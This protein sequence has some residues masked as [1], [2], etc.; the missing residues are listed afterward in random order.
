MGSIQKN[1]RRNAD[2]NSAGHVV[3]FHAVPPMDSCGHVLCDYADG[4]RIGCNL[5]HETQ[6]KTAT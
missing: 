6:K 3:D 5:G 4:I 2:D 1:I